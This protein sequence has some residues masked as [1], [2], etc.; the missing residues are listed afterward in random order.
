MVPSRVETYSNQ[1]IHF[2][3]HFISMGVIITYWGWRKSRFWVVV[4]GGRGG[5]PCHLDDFGVWWEI[6]PG[7]L[8]KGR[9]LG[10]CFQYQSIGMCRVQ[11]ARTFWFQCRMSIL[12]HYHLKEMVSKQSKTAKTADLEKF[13]TLPTTYHSDV[14]IS[15]KC[16]GYFIQSYGGTER[17]DTF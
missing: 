10:N 16:S 8:M 15:A 4:E 3:F 5:G 17:F 2:I 13:A 7:T 9:V 6:C 14:K 1:R 11:T 12:E